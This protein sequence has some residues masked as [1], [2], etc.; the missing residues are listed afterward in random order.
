M[1][2]QDIQDKLKSEIQDVLAELNGEQLTY[3]VLN[4]M[5]YMDC[6]V[7]EGLRKW[8]FNA[9]TDRV[10]TKSVE[11]QDPETGESIQLN[12]GDKV[13]IP[14]V[15]LHRDPNYFPDP[16]KFDPDRFSEENK[17]NINPSSYIPFGAGPRMCIA[18]RFAFMEIK[19]ILFYMFS[20]LRVDISEM[21][22]IPLE[23]DPTS[24]HPLPKN[25][26]WVKILDDT[27]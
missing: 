1:E 24:A 21:S 12:P 7:S 26:F 10:C 20:D 27:K 5:K 2:N 6:V 25:G 16:M 11:I 23:L 13:M 14:I 3:E 22:N 17:N 9:Q 4:N 19:V 8:P 18:H 15:G